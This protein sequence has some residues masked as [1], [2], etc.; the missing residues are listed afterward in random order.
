MICAL[1]YSGAAAPQEQGVSKGG[2][3]LGHIKDTTLLESPI[4][5]VRVVFVKADGAEFETQ[6]DADGAYEHAGLPAG[7]YLVNIYKPGYEDRVG[8]PVSV[9]DGGRH[10]VPMTMNKSE[11]ILSR[12]QNFFSVG[13]KRGGVL[14]FWVHSRTKPV[15]PID[16]VE[17]KITRSRGLDPLVVTGTSG[18]DGQYRSDK[19]PQGRY[20]VTLSKNGYQGVCPMAVQ[21]GRI[22]DARIQLPIPN[23]NA[24]SDV[25]SAQKSDQLNGKNIIR[26]KIRE[27][28]PFE[29]PMGDVDVVIKSVDGIAF[30]GTSN[31]DGDYEFIGLPA[32]RY[33]INLS[34]KGYIDKEG[35]PII[36]AND[37]NH[38]VVVI[39]EGMFV[40]YA[41]VAN[42]HLFELTH[43]MRR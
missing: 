27:M 35:I 41:S 1:L 39:E 38:I 18:A 43:G 3:I 20:I 22:T 23:R 40:S 14:R 16:G 32:G 26:G 8:E 29:I 7:R 4:N 34:K 17:I 19:L 15:V 28:V 9:I 13:G 10:Y 5:G 37:G 30:K 21:E 12:L 2:T 24:D 36:V 33:L 11:N 6:S 42:G 25:P 31:A